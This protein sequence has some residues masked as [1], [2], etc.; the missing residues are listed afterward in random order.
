VGIVLPTTLSLAAAA[1]L[2]NLWLGMRIGRLR[3]SEKVLHGDGGNP[4]IARRMRAQLNFAE[5]VPLILLLFAGVEL[6][7]RGGAWLSLV[8]GV[9]ILGRVAHAFGM[10]AG[11]PHKARMA[12]VAIT[13]LTGLGLAVYAVLIAARVA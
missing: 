12:G 4:L 9:F 6:A 11:H 3:V 13:M 1:L 5:N 7:G 10:D 8:G 2:V